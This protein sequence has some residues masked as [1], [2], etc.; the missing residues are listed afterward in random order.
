MPGI[1]PRVVNL[2]FERDK[3]FRKLRGVRGGILLRARTDIPRR[4]EKTY[5]RN[6]SGALQDFRV[7]QGRPVVQ[8]PWRCSQQAL[9]RKVIRGTCRFVRW[10]VRVTELR[11]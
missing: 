7:G 3:S 4:C 8:S 10:S 5:S 9:R 11:R 6:S 1:R 2:I